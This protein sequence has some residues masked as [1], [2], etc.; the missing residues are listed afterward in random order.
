[1]NKKSVLRMSMAAVP[2]IIICGL[3]VAASSARVDPF[4]LNL[5]FV[6]VRHGTEIHEVLD[7]NAISTV[8]IKVE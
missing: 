7:A 8:S 2:A 4:P 5:S 6:V 3:L 1:M